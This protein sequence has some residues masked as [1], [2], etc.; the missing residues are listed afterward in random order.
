MVAYYTIED[1]WWGEDYGNVTM[2]PYHR[3]D[4]LIPGSW[5][6]VSGMNL[7]GR[8]TR[9]EFWAGFVMGQSNSP[10]SLAPDPALAGTPQGTTDA[11]VDILG[12]VGYGLF[13][14]E[15]MR[16]TDSFY[17]QRSDSDD[18]RLIIITTYALNA[19]QSMYVSAD[20]KGGIVF[21]PVNLPMCGLP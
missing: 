8:R 17:L 3:Q 21:T 15:Q 1:Y 14:A 9:T 20:Q 18:Y 2:S 10:P 19:D 11:A 12:M 7:P 16:H 6:I 13:G 5:Q 4:P